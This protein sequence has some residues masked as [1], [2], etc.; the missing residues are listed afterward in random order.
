ANDGEPAAV[1][2]ISTHHRLEGESVLTVVPITAIAGLAA[3]AEWWKQLGVP[4]PS[5][6]PALPQ[7]RAQTRSVLAAQRDRLSSLLAAARAAVAEHPYTIEIDGAPA[8]STVYLRQQ[9][10]AQVDRALS[11]DAGGSVPGQEPAGGAKPDA[12]IRREPA[13]GPGQEPAT[14]PGH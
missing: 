9:L 2:V 7:Q 8:L 5:A 11:S 3:A 1:G 6:L 12:G 14:S 13:D 4:G 10:G